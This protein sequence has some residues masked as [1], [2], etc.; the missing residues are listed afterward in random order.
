VQAKT[1]SANLATLRRKLDI[2]DDSQ[3]SCQFGT[4]TSHRRLK[5]ARKQ[6]EEKHSGIFD[7]RTFGYL[8]PKKLPERGE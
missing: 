5:L 2:V 3:Q 6:N 7:S 4:I 1:V 8:L